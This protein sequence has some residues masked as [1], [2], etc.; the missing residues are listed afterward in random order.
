MEK[1]GTMRKQDH[2]IKYISTHEEEDYNM[3]IIL[4]NEAGVIAVSTE[5]FESILNTAKEL[6]NGS[7]HITIMEK[8]NAHF[9]YSVRK[10]DSET[11]FIKF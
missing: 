11:I 1:S 10:V 3:N 8:F 6:D 2:C 5:C 4:N 7:D 9:H